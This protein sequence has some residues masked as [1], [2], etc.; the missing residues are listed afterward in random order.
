[1]FDLTTAA[2]GF[3]VFVAVLY[4]G[5][6]LYYDRRDRRRFDALRRKHAFHCVRCNEVYA[7]PE[8]NE[9]AVCPRCGR[10][11]ARLRF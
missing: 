11:N 1:M 10:E 4:L 8:G 7:S 3:C 2:V 6:W 5:L 9:V